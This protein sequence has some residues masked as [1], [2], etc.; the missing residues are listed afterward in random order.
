MQG[1]RGRDDESGEV[2]GSVGE[3][4]GLVLFDDAFQLAL[5]DGAFFGAFVHAPGQQRV[6]VHLVSE[7]GIG[8]DRL[9]LRTGGVLRTLVGE[10]VQVGLAVKNRGEQQE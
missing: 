2:L 10:Q 7:N 5:L 8:F 1:C 4:G 3:L 6:P 9:G